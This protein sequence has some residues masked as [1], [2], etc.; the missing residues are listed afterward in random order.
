MSAA[1]RITAGAALALAACSAEP[2]YLL[3]TIERGNVQTDTPIR[4]LETTIDLDGR[5][6]MTPMLEPPPGADFV[7]PTTLTLE[8]AEGTGTVRVGANAYG[9]NNL[10]L[11]AGSTELTLAP[12]EII[13]VTVVLGTHSTPPPDGGVDESVLAISP[14]V[15]DF[16]TITAGTEATQTFTVGNSG[17]GPSKP[18][19]IEF[20]D[21]NVPF[22][23]V[24]NNCANVAL[25]RTEECTFGVRFRPLAVNTWATTIAVEGYDFN[26]GI[27]GAAALFS[28]DPP[29]VDFGAVSTTAS[30]TVTVRNP[31]SSESTR[32]LS[33]T[34]DG[35]D[36]LDFAYTLGGGNCDPSE[37]LAPGTSCTVSIHFAPGS[38]GAKNATFK[39]TD[40]ATM[41]LALS[42]SGV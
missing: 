37:E 17:S 7:L 26:N 16:S 22:T 14:D 40:R 9:A 5:H 34:I 35:P 18:L 36:S 33:F 6:D 12:G 15:I 2:T 20:A 39:V 27:N 29:A 10:L 19:R 41:Q 11:S 21:E 30:V 24:D 38:P 3:T 23:I 8:L 32:A 25:P 4:G 31:S 13:P 1:L 42:G 28:L